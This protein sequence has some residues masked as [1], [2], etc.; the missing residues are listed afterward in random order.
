MIYI[1]YHGT[2]LKHI[3]ASEQTLTDF[4]LHISHCMLQFGRID[5]QLR[6]LTV[7][8]TFEMTLHDPKLL[9]ITSVIHRHR[10]YSSNSSCVSSFVRCVPVYQRT[11]VQVLTQF[12]AQDSQSRT[13]HLLGSSD[14]FVDVTELVHNWLRVEDPLVAYLGSQNTLIGLQPGRTS[15]H[16]GDN[17]TS[18]GWST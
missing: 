9:C 6:W 17:C 16:V 8:K 2:L 13:T 11:S 15:L 1:K 5:S 3:Q 14:W 4:C 10:V 12:T 7:S 18:T